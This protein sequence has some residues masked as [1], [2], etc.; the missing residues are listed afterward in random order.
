[1]RDGVEL[2]AYLVN[3]SRARRPELAGD[4][5]AGAWIPEGERGAVRDLWDGYAAEVYPHD[6]LV[7]SLRGRFIA[8]TLTRALAAD[9]ATVLVVCGAGFSSYPWLLPFAAAVEVDLP[10]MVA[11]KRRRAAELVDGGVADDRD[12]H[13]VAADL[14][15]EADRKEVTAAVRDVAGGRPVAYVAEG[16]VFY[17]PPAEAEAVVTLGAAFGT[18]AVTAVSYW[19]AAAA[20][21]TVLAGQRG[22]F[23]RRAVPPEASYLTH[24]RLAGLLGPGLEDVGPEDLQRR[25]LG[26]IGVREAELI[27]EYVAVS[28]AARAGA[29]G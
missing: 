3:E 9:P 28:W 1:M 27:P 21:S 10:D 16:L 20:G 19:P 24:D 13:H 18:T 17:L 12:V 29:A 2:T 22:W 6:D 7:V 4:R 14:S 8:D 23:R 25:Y 5:L 26:E 15:R 11:A